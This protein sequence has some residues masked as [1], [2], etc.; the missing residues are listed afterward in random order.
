[1]WATYIWLLWLPRYVV[2]KYIERPLL[3]HNTKFDIRQWVLVTDWNPL[4]IW[5]YKSS[6]LRS[7]PYWEQF[8]HRKLRSNYV[9]VLLA[10]F[11]NWRPPWVNS[12]LQQCNSGLC[13]SI[14]TPSIAFV[15]NLTSYI[16][17][18]KIQEWGAFLLSSWWQY[19]GQWHIHHVRLHFSFAHLFIYILIY[20]YLILLKVF[21][22]MFKH[23]MILI[24]INVGQWQI[25]HSHFPHAYACF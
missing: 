16:F 19:V 2:Q 13:L 9:Q 20:S 23:T 5:M 17:A 11:Q 18:D 3:I 15:V 22:P 21:I 25:Y 10:A 1:M 14:P 7:P 12:P 4:V 6:Y 24:L 8:I